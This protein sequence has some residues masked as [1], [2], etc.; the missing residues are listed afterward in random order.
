[1]EAITIRVNT[2]LGAEVVDDADIDATRVAFLGMVQRVGEGYG[3]DVTMVDAGELGD[4]R[5]EGACE[6]W[7][8]IRY[9][10]LEVVEDGR[11]VRMRQQVAV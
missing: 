7:M 8:S 2:A 11:Y 3:Y 1:M 4:T 9:A 5:I 6:D 10:I